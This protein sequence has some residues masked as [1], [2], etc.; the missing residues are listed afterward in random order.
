MSR[1]SDYKYACN[2]FSSIDKNKKEHLLIHYSCESFYNRTDG[3]SPRITC[4]AVRNFETAQTKTFS[5]HKVAEIEHISFDDIKENY[6]KLEEIMLKNFFEFL[7]SNRDKKWIHW[8]MRDSN[9]GFQAIEHRYQVLS[10]KDTISLDDDK[11]IDL[12]RLLIKKYS[13]HYCGNPRLEKLC[14]INHNKPKDFLSGSNEASAF[15]NKEFIKLGMSTV[16]KVDLFSNIL[17]L[18]IDGK[19][20]TNS[21]KSDIYGNF[22]LEYYDNLTITP[23]GK[24]L[25]NIVSLIVGGFISLYISKVFS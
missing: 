11:K 17:T 15:E 12:S 9:Y 24:I 25:T 1:Y 3:K 22:I 16:S 2:I 23:L 13:K 20:K 21:K 18:E 5:I 6:D 14:E 7:N 19:L 4:I 8:N 10:G